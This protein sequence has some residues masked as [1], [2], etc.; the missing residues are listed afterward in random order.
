MKTKSSPNSHLSPD[1]KNIPWVKR[2]EQSRHYWQNSTSAHIKR[3]FQCRTVLISVFKRAIAKL[4]LLWFQHI[5][6]F[7][8][9]CFVFSREIC[10]IL[11]WRSLDQ[12][13]QMR[14]STLQTDA[15]GSAYA[16]ACAHSCW[17]DWWSWS[18][19]L[20]SA[21]FPDG[22]SLLKKRYKS[23]EYGGGGVWSSLD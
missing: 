10:S 14:Y 11:L 12:C 21:L 13:D 20:P 1:K 4:K 8:F 5:R 15:P 18:A 17:Q 3:K 2:A 6:G 19:V 22:P 23:S 9:F 7:L 16:A